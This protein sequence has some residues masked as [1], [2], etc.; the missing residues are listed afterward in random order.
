MRIHR[1]TPL[2]FALG[3]LAPTVA[4]PLP[5][6]AAFPG[7]DGVLAFQLE[8]P[9]GDHTQNDIYTI[10][11]SGAGLQRLTATPDEHEF[12]P[13][14]YAASN[15]IAFRRSPAPFRSGTI[16]SIKPPRTPPPVV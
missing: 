8:A 13:A 11:P 9:A 15:R 6:H 4:G 10:K 2:A 3:L 7:T 14:W 12:G 1:F 5:A 16:V